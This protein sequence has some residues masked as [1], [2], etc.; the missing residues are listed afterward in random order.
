LDDLAVGTNENRLSFFLANRETILPKDPN[1]EYEVPA[2]GLMST[3]D[4]NADGRTDIVILY[5]HEDKEG[6]ANLLLSE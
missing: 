1:R 2:Y 3:F 5:T 6:L 4:L